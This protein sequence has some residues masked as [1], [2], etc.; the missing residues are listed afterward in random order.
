MNR[1]LLLPFQQ[2]GSAVQKH[3]IPPRAKK[4]P[5]VSRGSQAPHTGVNPPVSGATPRLRPP[6]PSCQRGAGSFLHTGAD[7]NAP[8]APGWR[9]A[10]LSATAINPMRRA[11]LS[12]GSPTPVWVGS[13]TPHPSEHPRPVLP[14]GWAQPVGVGGAVGE[15]GEG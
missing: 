6:V 2:I 13:A 7:D 14:F 8:R 4:L 3:R 1:G 10:G 5:P 11:A 15:Q 9:G 12:R